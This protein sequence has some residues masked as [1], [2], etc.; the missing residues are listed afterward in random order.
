MRKNESK[1]KRVK[2]DRPSGDAAHTQTHTLTTYGVGAL[3]VLN[4]ILEEMKLDEFLKS[5]LP[6]ED[7]RTKVAAS[8]TLLVLV[9]NL[10]MARDPIYGVGEWAAGY[11][12]D[13]MGLTPDQVPL[14]ND[15]RAGRCLDKL[16]RSDYSSLALTLAS[17]VVKHFG[18]R[19]DELH[20]DSTTIT[21]FGAYDQDTV[22][23]PDPNAPP[24]LLTWGH[25]KDHRPDLKQLLYILTVSGDGAVPVHFTAASGNVTDDTTHRD[26]WDLLCQLAG[27][28]D[29][30][31]VADCKLASS[32]NMNHI[33]R[34]D[35]RFIT[36]L[37]RTRKE[38]K[39]FR[40]RLLQRRISW[41]MIKEERND[42][43]EVVDRVSVSSE[44]TLSHDGFSIHWYHSTRKVEVDSAARATRL[45][46]ALAKLA[47]LDARLQGPKPRIRTR[48][49]AVEAAIDILRQCDVE[50]L[51][52]I[53]AEERHI[54]DYRQEQ[55]GRPT[56]D[57]R[58][59]KEVRTSCV[60]RYDLDQEAIEREE[61][62][63]GVFPLI[64]NVDS[65]CA[66][67]VLEAYK[68]QP[69]VEKRFSQLK[70]DFRVAPVYL[71]SPL[72]IEALLCVYFFVLMTQAL[73]EREL[74]RAMERKSLTAIRLYP[75]SRKCHRPTTRRVID[76]FDNIQRHVLEV[77]GKAQVVMVTELSRVQRQ[78]LALVSLP[79][80]R[81]G[82]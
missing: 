23:S 61:A 44:C 27:R 26:T 20:N 4:H 34:N 46:R 40:K 55:R 71:K 47:E 3:P 19:L 54:E 15:D 32:E 24:L 7:A 13:L 79:A 76:L 78:V 45:K 50:G 74:R 2:G 70:T 62:G 36:V 65:L 48:V 11:A 39:E 42:Q 63:D 75:E 77:R 82:R 80:A 69:L 52:R 56:K 10:L 53:D 68:K 28:R 49:K 33:D 25:N 59:V 18:V 22:E 67:E 57:T 64:T 9:K 58:Y 6:R 16:C 31:Y 17:H 43:D 60:L 66:R 73:V 72:R 14:L 12:P 8:R 21:F 1:R 38:D 30:L 51:I 35:G 5:Y 41:R 29:F 81:Y 37:P